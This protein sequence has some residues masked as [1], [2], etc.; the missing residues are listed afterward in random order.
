MQTQCIGKVYGPEDGDLCDWKIYG[1]PDTAFSVQKPDTV[2]HTCATVVN[3]IPS[4]ISAPAGYITMEKL[5]E[6]RYL[7]YPMHLSL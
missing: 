5:P 6:A 2:A 4:V 7:S 3:R 1:T